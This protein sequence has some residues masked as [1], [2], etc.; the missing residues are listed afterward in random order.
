MYRVYNVEPLQQCYKPNPAGA[1]C[2]TTSSVVI[3]YHCAWGLGAKQS[4]LGVHVAVRAQQAGAVLPSSL[5]GLGI[6]LR[7]EACVTSIH[8][9]SQSCLD[10]RFSFFFFLRDFATVHKRQP[11]Y[12]VLNFVLFETGFL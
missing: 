1:L 11:A 6:R 2:I 4:H 8:L 10:P 7:S 9:L 12:G 3:S 5:R